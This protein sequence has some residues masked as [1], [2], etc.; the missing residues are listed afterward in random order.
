[1]IMKIFHKFQDVCQHHCQ[2]TNAVMSNEQH[3]SCTYTFNT[4][5]HS[6]NYRCCGKTFS[7]TYSEC[8]F[9]AL[10]MQHTKCMHCIVPYLLKFMTSFFFFLIWCLNMRGLKFVYKAPNRTAANWITLN[11]TMRSQ[12]KACI[13]RLSCE[14]FSTTF[15]RNIS[16]SQ[17]K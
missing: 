2:V 11:W 9:V 14:I 5:A 15:V 6:C 17:K 10:I 3:R 4:E 12:T 8:V 13:A 7:I 16:H 1:M